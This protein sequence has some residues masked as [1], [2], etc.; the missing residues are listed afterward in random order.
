MLPHMPQFMV[1]LVVSTQPVVAQHDCPAA[2]WPMPLHWQTPAEHVSLAA[3]TLPQALQFEESFIVSTHLPLQ[4]PVGH[5]AHAAGTDMS[6][7]FAPPSLLLLFGVPQPIAS[8]ASRVATPLAPALAAS[9]EP[10]VEA[11]S[12]GPI[13]P[14]TGWLQHSFS[15]RA[16]SLISRVKPLGRLSQGL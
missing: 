16:I 4:Q 2:Q 6:G 13:R 5:L 15:I 7:L 8:S 10:T 3:H 1:S 11:W 9:R 14:V 12:E